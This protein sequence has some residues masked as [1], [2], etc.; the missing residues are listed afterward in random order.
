MKPGSQNLVNPTIRIQ[1]RSISSSVSNAGQ[2]HHPYPM[3]VNL[4]IRIQCRSISSSVSNA[5]QSHHEFSSIYFFPDFLIPWFP[6]LIG[7]LPLAFSASSFLALASIQIQH[8]MQEGRKKKQEYHIPAACLA[9]N[10]TSSSSSSFFS[11]FGAFNGLALPPSWTL[12]MPGTNGD[13]KFNTFS[14]LTTHLIIKMQ[15]TDLW[16]FGGDSL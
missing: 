14:T 3:Q 15:V 8:F 1:C 13:K 10:A 6:E 5:G 9:L 12:E 11:F 4:I 7:P 2:S 16:S